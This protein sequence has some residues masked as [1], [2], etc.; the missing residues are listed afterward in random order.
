VAKL[1]HCLEQQE[2]GHRQSPVLDSSPPQAMG[3]YIKKKKSHH[4]QSGDAF[5]AEINHQ[6][7]FLWHLHKDQPLD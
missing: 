3:F 5:A 7:L 1:G 2:I 4:L 6:D